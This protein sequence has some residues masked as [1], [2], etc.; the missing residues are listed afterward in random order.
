M[1]GNTHTER[2]RHMLCFYSHY[3]D[4]DTV[5]PACTDGVYFGSC[6]G[7]VVRASPGADIYTG[8]LIVIVGD[9]QYTITLPY[10]SLGLIGL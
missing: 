9:E 7:D 4:Q 10:L 3:P 1:F 5:R 8:F 6:N 2:H